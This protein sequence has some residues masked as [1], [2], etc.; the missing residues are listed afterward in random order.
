[1][2]SAVLLTCTLC[3][4]GPAVLNV[5]AEQSCLRV[6]KP[7]DAFLVADDKGHVLFQQN[8][9]RKYTPAS[10]LKCLTALTAIRNLGPGYRFLTEFYVG[11]DR[12]LKVKGYGDPLLISEV[13]EEIAEILG[14]KIRGFTDL[15]LDDTY[16]SHAITIPGRHRSTNPYDAPP[17]ALCANFNTVLFERDRTGRIVSAEKQTPMIPFVEDK[18][19]A[20]G[21]QEGR[22]TFTHER[23]E[24]TRYAGE[25]LLHF[26]VRQGVTATGQ[27]RL[28]EITSDD[29]LVLSYRSRFEL[30]DGLKKMLAYSNNFMAN[31]ILIAVGAHAYGPPA[32][33]A[34]GIKVVSEFIQ[35]DLGLTGTQIVE[36]SGISRQ[37]RLSAADMLHILKD[38]RPYRHLLT[39]D[40]SF[41]Y[42]TGSLRGIR[43]R[44]GYVSLGV[45][46]PGY[47]VVFLQRGGQDV[48]RLMK[49]SEEI[50]LQGE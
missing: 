44:A 3:L 49:C 35:N 12:S 1:M 48:V 16:F 11:P 4:H 23:R 36:G 26:L 37:N 13:W 41:K 32:T 40:N 9:A 22:L 14:G 15:V 50:L 30:E 7:D 18:I 38:F 25:M 20:I 39:T 5:D 33:L 31:Q 10:T 46:D 42:K 45:G 43:T 28:G 21:A 47:F 8:A 34:K 27:I 29:R 2:G 6:L 17:G 19:R 24:A